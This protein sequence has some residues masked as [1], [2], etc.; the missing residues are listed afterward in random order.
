MDLAVVGLVGLV[1]LYIVTN[2][3]K[4]KKCLIHLLS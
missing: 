1:G 3:E 2:K 4:V